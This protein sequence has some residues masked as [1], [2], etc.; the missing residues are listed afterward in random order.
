MGKDMS[1]DM[2]VIILVGLVGIVTLEFV[3]LARGVDGTMFG[4]AMAATGT[5]VGYALK[6]RRSE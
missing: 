5:I 1:K 3:A 6:S 4:A 2:V